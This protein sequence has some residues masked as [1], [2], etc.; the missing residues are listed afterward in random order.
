MTQVAC[1]LAGLVRR[2]AASADLGQL[3]GAET[4]DLAVSRRLF[5]FF[6]FFFS[7]KKG[8]T[9]VEN[10]M[11]AVVKNRYALPPINM[12]LDRG[13][14]KVVFQEPPNVRFHVS[15]WKGIQQ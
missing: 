9:L 3:L 7:G 13:S 14:R 5:C 4:L 11:G 1:R 12:E 8:V 6:F 15:W 2:G 10:D